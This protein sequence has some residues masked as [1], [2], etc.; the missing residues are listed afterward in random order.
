M[1]ACKTGG[2]T[3]S[4]ML[5]VSVSS[6]VNATASQIG[7]KP[8]WYR[9]K[10]RLHFV[11]SNRMSYVCVTAHRRPIISGRRAAMWSAV[12]ATSRSAHEPTARRCS[13]Q[14]KHALRPL[15]TQAAV[16]HGTRRRGRTSA[17]AGGTATPPP[18]PRN[19]AQLVNLLG[20]GSKA[21]PAELLPGHLAAVMDGWAATCGA[22][23]YQAGMDTLSTVVH[24][25]H[26]WGVPYL[27]VRSHNCSSS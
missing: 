24:C 15:T 20:A 25:C 22:A 1:F 3:V 23:G 10:R 16:S 9:L 26:D 4:D 11:S 2:G 7:S 14:A 21:P 6:V 19:A 13:P 8:Y 17:V 27:T 12:P 5:G 18:P